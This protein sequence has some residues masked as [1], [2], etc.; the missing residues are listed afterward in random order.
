VIPVLFG[1]SLEQVDLNDNPAYGYSKQP[2]Y[3]TGGQ[4]YVWSVPNT[5]FIS[6]TASQR[7]TSQAIGLPRV[8]PTE[9]GQ[10]NDR[11]YYRGSVLLDS[12]VAGYS[13][14]NDRTIAVRYALVTSAW[15]GSLVNISTGEYVDG[16]LGD[17][18]G[19]VPNNTVLT[20]K[21]FTG[22]NALIRLSL[23][24]SYRWA[25]SVDGEMTVI[26]LRVPYNPNI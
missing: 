18:T 1:E 14:S 15:R 8:D 24:E 11:G 7:S 9:I 12:T 5:N 19:V 4:P 21:D 25:I 3:T 20:L 16:S 10:V 6:F 2:R 22:P 17:W 13:G 26:N 23:Q